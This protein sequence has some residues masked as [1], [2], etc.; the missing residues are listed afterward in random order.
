MERLDIELNKG[1]RRTPSFAQNGELDECVGLYPKSGELRNIPRMTALK[2]GTGST[3]FVLPS[4]SH[5]L[6]GL[7]ATDGRNIYISRVAS[8]QSQVLYSN[9]WQDG[10]SRMSAQIEGFVTDESV[11]ILTLGRIM[12]A[13]DATGLHYF[14]WKADGYTFLGNKVPDLQMRFG[15]KGELVT[16]TLAGEINGH[17]DTSGIS[18]QGQGYLDPDNTHVRNISNQAYGAAAK[19][20]ADAARDGY[21]THPFF[22]RYAI[23]LY[24][25]SHTNLSAPVLM[26]VSSNELFMQSSNWHSS[27]TDIYYTMIKAQLEYRIKADNLELFE[28]WGD[29]VKG[30]DIYVTVPNYSYKPDGTRLLFY[31]D[32]LSYNSFSYSTINSL[33]DSWGFSICRLTNINSSWSGSFQNNNYVKRDMM[34]C[35]ALFFNNASLNPSKMAGTGGWNALLALDRRNDGWEADMAGDGPYYLIKSYDL[36]ELNDTEVTTVKLGTDRLTNLTTGEVL[37]ETETFDNIVSVSDALIYNRRLALSDIT[38]RVVCRQSLFTLLPMSDA[39]QGWYCAEGTGLPT[40]NTGDWESTASYNMAV[41]MTDMGGDIIRVNDETLASGGTVF[42][43]RS[44]LLYLSYLSTD[45]SKLTVYTLVD[46]TPFGIVLTGLRKN[47]YFNGT[48]YLSFSPLGS[49][50]LTE[51]TSSDITPTQ[52]NL[53]SYPSRLLVSQAENPFVYSLRNYFEVG[54]GRVLRIATF[55]EPLSSGQVGQ[56]PLIAFCS[57]GMWALEINR[58]DGTFYDPAPVSPDVLS[59]LSSL[60]TIEG[61]LLYVT[62]QGLKSIGI[63]KEI[64]LLSG[65]IE[66]KNIDESLYV[67]SDKPLYPYVS[68]WASLFTADVAEV[69]EA[70]QDCSI[71][72]D[73]K[74]NLVHIFLSQAKHYVLSLAS[75]E[76]SGQID[77]GAKP[78]AVIEDYAMSVMQFPSDAHLYV[79]DS[80][81]DGQNTYKGWCLSRILTIGETNMY[82]NIMQMKVY[83]SMDNTPSGSSALKTAL[84]VSNDKKSWALLSSLKG[85]SYKYYRFALFTD[86]TDLEAVSGISML[87]NPE[88]GNKLR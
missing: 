44:A 88:R 49:S 26:W 73:N 53:K 15:L 59:N 58:N 72:Y 22:V 68:G 29:L 38:E 82:A 70:L 76:F 28:D 69:R 4:S 86:M 79:Y 6:L 23:R 60:T 66:G 57:D 14:I 84:F 47:I 46:S 8:G 78:A 35:H 83:H 40:K 65:P 85:A 61:G 21:F 2:D 24:D 54:S 63:H 52:D 81:A 39:W 41:E 36:S 25:G 32:Y 50:P 16:S 67:G 12:M 37:K 7:H 5:I 42:N 43:L 27:S 48:Y 10:A 13:L 9:V 30:V 56:F 19:V 62:C 31:A 71:V 3:D 80:A 45:V 11:Q 20:T 17:F 77:G 18:Y 74:N 51:L 1:I 75:L 87:Y 55:T 64:R 33:K 34:L